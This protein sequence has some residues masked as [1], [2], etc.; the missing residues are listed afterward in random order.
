MLLN[1][2]LQNSDSYRGAVKVSH[3]T[4]Y[5]LQET[6]SLSFPDGDE[7]RTPP[8]FPTLII[9]LLPFYRDNLDNCGGR[10]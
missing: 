8:Y 5:Q 6:E 2:T 4:L 3:Q 7:L 9:Y 1:Q 10:F